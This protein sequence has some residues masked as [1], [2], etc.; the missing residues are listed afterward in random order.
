MQTFSVTNEIRFK[1]LMA[2]IVTS[3]FF[4]L[5]KISGRKR[6]YVTSFDKSKQ[7]Q[8]DFLSRS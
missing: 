8:E 5:N 7:M 3:V 4:F 1:R 2:V 6:N